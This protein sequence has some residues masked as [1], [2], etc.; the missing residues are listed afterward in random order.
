MM[1]LPPLK[2]PQLTESQSKIIESIKKGPR[3]DIPM[4]GPFGVWL[5]AGN[6]GDAIQNLGASLRYETIL[7]EK[8]KEFAICIVGHHY[9]TKFEFAYHER[10]AI[11]SGLSAEIINEI[12]NGLASSLI[13]KRLDLT[14]QISMQLLEMHSITDELYQQGFDEFGEQGMIELVSLVG[15]YC[16]VSLTLNAFKIPIDKDME[17]PF[18]DEK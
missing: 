15:Y 2:E 4:T 9:K 6:I 12:K 14:R 11:K 17:D 7:D 5:R 10:L 16:L 3:G 8:V 1:R 13:D 18:P